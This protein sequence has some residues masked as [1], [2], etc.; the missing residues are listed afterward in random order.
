MEYDLIET[1]MTSTAALGKWE[2]AGFKTKR[3][4]K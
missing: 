1:N 2:Y 3:T 4:R